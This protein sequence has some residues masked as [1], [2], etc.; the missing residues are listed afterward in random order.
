[1]NPGDPSPV[2][3]RACHLLGAP[4]FEEYLQHNASLHVMTMTL[5]LSIGTALGTDHHPDVLQ[6]LREDAQD[7]RDAADRYA[8]WAERLADDWHARRQEHGL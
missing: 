2:L 7:L 6:A 3:G 5:S 1:M 4:R 8:A